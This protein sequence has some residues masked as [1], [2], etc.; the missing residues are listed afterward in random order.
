MLEDL[1]ITGS[2]D[3]SVQHATTP[4][5]SR[6]PGAQRSH[7]EPHLLDYARVIVK[8]RHIALA[9]F[10]VVALAALVYSFT[11]TPIYEGRV[12]LLIESNDPNILDFKQVTG[13]G[14]N[15]NQ[16]SGLSGTRWPE[17]V[18][19]VVPLALPSRR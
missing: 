3:D 1:Q 6:R 17:W 18:K 4:P 8:R 14:V 2:P 11:A 15:A 16:L 5:V 19:P 7:P 13:D 10:S 12:Q 9:A